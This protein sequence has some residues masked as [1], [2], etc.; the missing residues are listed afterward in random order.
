M[1]RHLFCAMGA[2]TLVVLLACSEPPTS[3]ATILQFG[4]AEVDITPPVG[5][6]LGG[7]GFPMTARRAT[8]THDPLLAQLALFHNDI[9]D[10][11][12]IVTVDAA[13]YSFDF[14]DWGPG[15]LAVRQTMAS[16]AW[17]RLTLAPEHIVITGSHSHA[18]TDLTGFW[19]DAEEG[20]DLDYLLFVENALSAA[21]LEAAA[22]LQTAELWL[23]HTRLPDYASRDDDCSDII[24]DRVEVMQVRAIDGA[25]LATLTNYARHPTIIGDENTEYSADYIWGYR[26]ALQ[27]HTEAPAL[28]IQGFIAAVH[29]GP[30]PIE[31]GDE[32]ERAFN[33]GTI[34][35]NAVVELEPNLVQVDALDIRHRSQRYE[36]EV[37]GAYMIQAKRL[38]DIPQRTVRDDGETLV[39]E[40]IEVSWHAIGPIEFATMPGEP[41]PEYGYMLRERMVGE[42]QFIVGLANDEVGYI[43]D[44]ESIAKDTS[45][46][47]EGYELRMGLGP[48]GGPCTWQATEAMGW[49]DGAGFE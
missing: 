2:C 40:N 35:A 36:C 21:L 17:P 26:E 45:G 1:G 11:F 37:Q 42:H 8:G 9:G 10:A 28:F 29:G 7:Y 6:I 16:R 33:F 15:I 24:D 39:A 41:T 32:W 27:A 20:P 3:E 47:L 4:Y 22:S 12:V 46:R 30:A 38:A 19:Q 14:D 31:G 23:G 49:F 44:P 18:A 43:I 48:A 34:I 13:G 5:A 25:T